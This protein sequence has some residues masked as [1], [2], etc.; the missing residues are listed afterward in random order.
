MEA[1]TNDQLR[2]LS[3]FTQTTLAG[4]YKDRPNRLEAQ[5]MVVAASQAVD[6]DHGICCCLLDGPEAQN[7]IS[8]N[9]YP[10]KGQTQNGVSVNVYPRAEQEQDSEQGVSVERSP[11]ALEELRRT[12]DLALWVT[13]QTAASIER[14]MVVM[15]A[16][17]RR[18]WLNLPDIGE[19]EKGF[20]LDAPVLPSELLGTSVE[21]V[22]GKFREV[23]YSV[24]HAQALL[25]S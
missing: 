6:S 11:E 2:E 25:N 16:T 3:T 22:V 9:V 21:A 14:S 5:N 10:C 17:E 12:T 20:L 1:F 4:K 24:Q 15:V 19:K 18:L 7:G 8:F 23:F 13:K